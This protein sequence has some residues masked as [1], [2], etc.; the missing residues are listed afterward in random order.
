MLL[1]FVFLNL[2]LVLILKGYLI[3]NLY[4]CKL[5]LC[6]VWRSKPLYAEHTIEPYANHYTRVELRDVKWLISSTVQEAFQHL[7]ASFFI[8]FIMLEIFYKFNLLI[9]IYSG[10]GTNL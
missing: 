3:L 1:V 10:S 5:R 7:K 2:L 9:S 4:L 6:S 8:V